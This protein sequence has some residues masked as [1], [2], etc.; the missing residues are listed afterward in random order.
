MFTQESEMRKQREKDL[1]EEEG[2]V[3]ADPMQVGK[4]LEI[5]GFIFKKNM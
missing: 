4:F 3:Y 5:F 2:M 1:A